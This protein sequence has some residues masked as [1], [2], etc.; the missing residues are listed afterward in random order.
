MFDSSLRAGRYVLENIG[1]TDFEAAEAERAFKQHDRKA[2]RELAQL[3][4]PERPIAENEAY[5]ARAR[6]LE[7]DLETQL[8]E[9][10]EG[11]RKDVA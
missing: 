6:E 8:T 9:I 10:L 5:L 4:D 3:W 1:L 7:R 2:V 11:T